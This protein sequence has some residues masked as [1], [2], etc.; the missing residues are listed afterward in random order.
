[1]M[2]GPGYFRTSFANMLR[3]RHLKQVLRCVDMS[4]GVGFGCTR[5]GGV[6]RRG[7]GVR[8][9]WSFGGGGLY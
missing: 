4:S 5:D 7:R 3:G 8:I 9:C 1:M 6:R 2:G